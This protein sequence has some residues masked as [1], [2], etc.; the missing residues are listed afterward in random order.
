M[1][2]I[3]HTIDVM[4]GYKRTRSRSRPRR[5]RAKSKFRKEVERIAERAIV[6]SNT[7]RNI[8]TVDTTYQEMTKDVLYAINIM[9]GFSTDQRDYN[10]VGNKIHCDGVRIRYLF[11]NNCACPNAKECVIRCFLARVDGNLSFLGG[12]RIFRDS[13]GN[14][15]GHDFYSEIKSP[16]KI[17]SPINNNYYHVL[18]QKTFKLA[19]ATSDRSEGHCKLGLCKKK[20]NIKLPIYDTVL[21]NEVDKNIFFFFYMEPT[22]FDPATNAWVD[23]SDV[24]LHVKSECYWRNT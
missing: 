11:N 7:P 4:P 21:W 9:D 15:N 23:P 22:T 20:L 13:D 6:K 17:L 1:S 2:H 3:F 10:H 18:W 8:N 24:W 12:E 14:G 16:F 5:R 19:P